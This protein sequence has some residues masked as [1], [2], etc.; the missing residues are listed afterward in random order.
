VAALTDD[1]AAL[2]QTACADYLRINAMMYSTVI[3]AM[4]Y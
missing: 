2:A 1:N 4:Q 3:S